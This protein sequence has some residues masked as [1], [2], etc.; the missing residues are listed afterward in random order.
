M[1]RKYVLLYANLYV[2]HRWL[3]LPQSDPSF[4]PGPTETKY[5]TSYLYSRA[6]K[7][8]KVKIVCFIESLAVFRNKESKLDTMQGYLM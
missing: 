8:R 1:L 2:A 4:S 6:S 3:N 7:V 5:S